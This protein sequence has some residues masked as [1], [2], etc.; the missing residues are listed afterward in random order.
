MIN[1][2][3]TSQPLYPT[4]ILPIPSEQEDP[5]SGSGYS[6]GNTLALP[7]SEPNFSQIVN[8]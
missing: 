3:F 2:S 6:G 5:P 7:G 8:M 4:E 1:G